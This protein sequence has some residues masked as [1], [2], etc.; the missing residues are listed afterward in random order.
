M[1]AGVRPALAAAVLVLALAGCRTAPPPAQ[2]LGPGADAPW[3]EQRA[4]LEKLERYTLAGRVAVAAG[5]QGFS[6]SL[7]YQQQAARSDLAI[8][9]P[10]G[11]GGLRVVVDGAAVNI[12]TAKGENFD[13][14]AAREE[15]ERRVG[16]ALPLEHL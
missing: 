13:G 8:D 4:A 5:E 2:V 10:L 1:R 16:F 3:L 9:G 15:F 14:S 7:R 11:M 6:G 12:T